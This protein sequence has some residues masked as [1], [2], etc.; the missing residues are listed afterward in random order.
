M[1]KTVVRYTLEQVI[2]YMD[3]AVKKAN[4]YVEQIGKVD[5]KLAASLKD[6]INS[7]Y[8]EYLVHV[9][10]YSHQWQYIKFVEALNKLFGGISLPAYTVN[11]NPGTVKYLIPKEDI[12]Y[13]IKKKRMM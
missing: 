12:K 3:N 11:N 7:L 1:Q 2:V 10:S 13:W 5:S 9:K 8:N 4:V 6:Q